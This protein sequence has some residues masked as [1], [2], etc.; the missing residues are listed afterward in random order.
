[1]ITAENIEEMASGTDG[2]VENGD[3]LCVYDPI[4]ELIWKRKIGQHVEESE[5]F[6]VNPQTGK[7]DVPFAL[8]A[9]YA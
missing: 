1:M 3:T 9:R 4:R 2:F 7:F 5:C 6:A 8:K